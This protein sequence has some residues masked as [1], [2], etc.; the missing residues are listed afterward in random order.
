MFKSR[1]GACCR[2]SRQGLVRCS[3]V[4]VVYIPFANGVS[5][6]S[7]VPAIVWCLLMFQFSPVA[8]FKDPD[9]GIKS[10][11]AQGYRTGP[12]RQATWAGGPV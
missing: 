12:P 7:G 4:C 10:T 5:T 9:R 8:E 3:E 6:D 2:E 1:L 11:P